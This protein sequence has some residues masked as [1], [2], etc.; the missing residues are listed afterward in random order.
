[1]FVLSTRVD[2]SRNGMKY[3]KEAKEGWEKNILRN[4]HIF[5]TIQTAVALQNRLTRDRPTVSYLKHYKNAL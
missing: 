5:L 1:M 3:M 4:I 2:T